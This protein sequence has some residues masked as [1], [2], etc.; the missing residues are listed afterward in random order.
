MY[1]AKKQGKGRLMQFSADEEDGPTT[2]RLADRLRAALSRPGQS[3]DRDELHVV[4]QPIV[5]LA[6]TEVVAVEALARWRHPQDGALPTNT[7]IAEA[8]RAGVLERLERQVLEHACRDV[9]RL[10]ASRV[11]NLAVH[12]NVSAER[13]GDPALV[14]TV[15][16]VLTRY[17]LPAAALVLEITE[18]VRVPDLAVAREVLGRLRAIGV[19]MALDDFGVGS[20]GMPYLLGLPVDMVKLDRALA[21]ST[22]EAWRDHRARELIR[23]ATAMSHGMG[24]EVVAEGIETPDQLGRLVALG[25]DYGQGFLFARPGALGDL[26]AARPVTAP[27]AP[28]A[29]G[30]VKA[31]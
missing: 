16:E 18:T 10:R 27:P 22:G 23:A 14:H 3:P 7:L 5:R 6:S 26:P 31:G 29:G 21:V 28:R 19:R 13:V 9:A 25:C 24:L 11:A 15:T 17:R 20:T 12:V 8:E 4:Y 1:R 30:T 2:E